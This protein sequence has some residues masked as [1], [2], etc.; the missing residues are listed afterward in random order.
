MYSET[1][2]RTA[3]LVVEDE[4]LLR[5]DAVDMIEDAGFKTH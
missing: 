5:M 2:Q 4:P 1:P 3:V